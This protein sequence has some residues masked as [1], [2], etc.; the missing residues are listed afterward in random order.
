MG[1]GMLGS[2]GSRLANECRHYLAVLVVFA[3]VCA[4]RVKHY[5]CFHTLSAGVVY[6]CSRRQLKAVD[7]HVAKH[8]RAIINAQ[9]RIET[10]LVA[11][12]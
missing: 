1:V 12:E 6:I 5:V 11:G 8:C 2:R 3:R 9:K 7:S 10:V 4:W